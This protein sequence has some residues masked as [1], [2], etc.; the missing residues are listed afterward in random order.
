M[1]MNVIEGSQREK[2]SWANG[3]PPLEIEPISIRSPGYFA[4]C[5]SN[6]E[7][8]ED[9]KLAKFSIISA[10]RDLE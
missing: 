7:I 1:M 5:Y 9:N 10:P 2:E 3:L 8:A 4:N 6:E